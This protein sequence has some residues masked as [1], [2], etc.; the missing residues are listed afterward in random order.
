MI[1]A[2]FPCFPCGW[3]LLTVQSALKIP[4]EHVCGGF[5][6]AKQSGTANSSQIV[7][8]LCVVVFGG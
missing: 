1:G 2:V 8:L 7:D 4:V 5:A 3:P 6:I